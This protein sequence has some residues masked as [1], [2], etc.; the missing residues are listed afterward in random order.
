M[1]FSFENLVSGQSK[2]NCQDNKMP[3]TK[4]IIKLDHFF[5]FSVFYELFL[6]TMCI[7]IIYIIQ[8]MVFYCC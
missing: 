3:L 7:F 4:P 1:A 8:F 2:A 6:V 5:S